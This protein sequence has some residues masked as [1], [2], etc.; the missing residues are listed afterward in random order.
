MKL[1]Y[2]TNTWGGV[3]GHPGGV[4]S[5]KDSYYLTHG[6]TEEAFKDIS[7]SGYKGIEIFEGN[8]MAYD[9]EDFKK[10]LTQYNL[11][12]VG[13][14]TGA[15]FIY[16]EILPE[17]LE[18]IETVAKRAAELGCIHLVVGGGAIRS[19]GI[20]ENDYEKLADG[21]NKVI[22]IANKYGLVPHYHPH[23]GSL[24]ESPEQIEKIFSLT[25]INFCPDTAHLEAGGGN[26]AELMKK[27]KDRLKYV[28]FKD[29][30]GTNFLPLGEGKQSFSAMMNV[31]N[32]IDFDGWITVELDAFDDPK[33]GAQISKDYLK[34]QFN[35]I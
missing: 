18:K 24:G 12:F 35:L 32:E 28:H 19:T 22:K 5:I 16:S 9:A 11:E 27:Y 29:L 31:L 33:K 13:V 21:L 7:E 4:T 20:Q 6:S 26:P 25:D 1:A 15:N 3:V 17:E 30:E 2:Q 34:N 14:Y 23:L 10:L 8:L